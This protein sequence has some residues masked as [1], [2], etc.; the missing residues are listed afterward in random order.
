MAERPHT[1]A[2]LLHTGMVSLCPRSEMHTD[3]KKN[4]LDFK[5]LAV[6]AAGAQLPRVADCQGSSFFFFFFFFLFANFV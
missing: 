6:P 3:L 4:T 2:W 5:V 1:V